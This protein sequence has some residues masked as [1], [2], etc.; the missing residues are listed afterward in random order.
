MYI[1]ICTHI[2]TYIYI[3][4]FI[5]A[6]FTY[7]CRPN[8]FF[9]THCLR[10]NTDMIYIFIHNMYPHIYTYIHLYMYLYTHIYILIYLYI[11]IYISTNVCRPNMFLLTHCLRENTD[12]IYIC[13]HNIYL[14]MYVNTQIYIHIYL[15]IYIYM[16]SHMYADPTCFC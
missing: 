3:Y 8:M 15:Y 5:Y 1:C 2:Y 13:I 11:Y 9:L 4:I 7:V 16:Y 12:M 10:G 14:Y 6:C